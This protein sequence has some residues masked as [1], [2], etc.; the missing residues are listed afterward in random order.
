MQGKK[1]NEKKL[2]LSF[3]CG[4]VWQVPNFNIPPGINFHL[5]GGK[6]RIMWQECLIKARQEIVWC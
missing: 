5:G 3:Y 1:L 6:R 2:L 4:F